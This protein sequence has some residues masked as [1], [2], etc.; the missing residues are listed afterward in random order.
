LAS[1]AYTYPRLWYDAMRA[2]PDVVGWMYQVLRGETT[3]QA[4]WTRLKR[5]AIRLAP[6]ALAFRAASL[7]TR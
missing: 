6:A 2:H 7:F 3:F 1:I 5:H 4:L